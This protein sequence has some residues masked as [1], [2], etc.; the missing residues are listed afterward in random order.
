MN[1]RRTLP[2]AVP[3]TFLTL[4]ALGT[5]SRSKGA[6]DIPMIRGLP[7]GTVPVDLETNHYLAP[8]KHFH[9]NPFKG[10]YDPTE[11]TALL[12]KA[13]KGVD[14]KRTTTLTVDTEA[15]TGGVK[16]IP[17]VTKQANA[18]AMRS[19]FWIQELEK[20]DKHGYPKLRLQYAQVVI[21]EFFPRLDQL[22]G[23]AQWPHVSINTLEKVY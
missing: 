23:L 19:T 1:R 4:L 12:E 11:P 13:N 20:K 9:D 18:S 5:S 7:I 2:F 8:Y 21:L 14:I 6:P 3:A 15:E 10:V 17:F 22:P 16:N